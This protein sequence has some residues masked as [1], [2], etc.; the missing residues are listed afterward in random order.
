MLRAM[1]ERRLAVCARVPQGRL[2]YVPVGG[3]MELRLESGCTVEES[4]AVRAGGSSTQ[5]L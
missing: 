3:R 2:S 4:R 1:D 5:Q